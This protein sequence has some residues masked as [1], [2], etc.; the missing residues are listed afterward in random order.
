MALIHTPRLLPK[1]KKIKLMLFFGITPFEI[2]TIYRLITQG[3]IQVYF[4]SELEKRAYSFICFESNSVAL[5]GLKTDSNIELS[6]SL[7][8]SYPIRLRTNPHRLFMRNWELD[9]ATSLSMKQDTSE[10]QWQN[11]IPLLQNALAGED[12][13]VVVGD[14][15]QSIYRFRGGK[16]KVYRV[17]RT[18]YTFI[19]LEK[20]SNL[21]TNFRSYDEVVR[22]NNAFF[23][24]LANHLEREEYQNMSF[25][26]QSRGNLQKRRICL[27]ANDRRRIRKRFY[28]IEFYTLLKIEIN[29]IN[30][31]IFAFWFG[32]KAME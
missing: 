9:T 15:K 23:T 17:I 3:F 29:V 7:I 10:L 21:D 4:I 22:F 2:A 32:K 28:W 26:K 31:V 19:H 6:Q 25:S 12:A 13:M 30:S 18:G 20:H 27:F 16:A 14:G 1:I 24:Y 8:K 11:L 5:E